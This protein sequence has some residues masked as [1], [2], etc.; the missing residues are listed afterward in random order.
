PRS[1]GVS[2]A[3]RWPAPGWRPRGGSRR[4]P[5][6]DNGALRVVLAHGTLQGDQVPQAESDAYPFSQADLDALSADYVALGH[7]HGVYP[8]WPDAE[9]CERAVC[10]CGT[11]EP[12]QFTGDARY[13]ILPTLEHS[14]PHRLRPIKASK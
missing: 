8:A 14:R 6:A 13:A 3:R 7:F 5:P 10:Y 9:E 1:C 11:H 4:P 12:D 2:A